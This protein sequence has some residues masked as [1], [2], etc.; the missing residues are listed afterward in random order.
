MKM[1]E[2]ILA[3]Y[4]I[5]GHS[6]EYLKQLIFRGNPKDNGKTTVDS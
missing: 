4:R 3:F 6:F 2:E 5:S 1:A